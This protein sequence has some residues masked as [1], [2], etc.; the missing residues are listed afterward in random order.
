MAANKREIR[1]I[2]AR[3]DR[4]DILPSLEEIEHL[5]D[6]GGATFRYKFQELSH[7]RKYEHAIASCSNIMRFLT[8]FAPRAGIE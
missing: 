7:V 8:S 1:T 5:A 2:W 3:T 4:F 6:M